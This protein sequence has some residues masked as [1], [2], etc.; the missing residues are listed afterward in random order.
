MRATIAIAAVVVLSCGSAGPAKITVRRPV[1][2]SKCPDSGPP[3][4]AKPELAETAG[5]AV[6]LQLCAFGD[7]FGLCNPSGEPTGMTGFWQ[8]S[9]AEVASIDSA[10][11]TFLGHQGMS[12]ET[13]RHLEQYGRQYLGFFRGARRYVFIN[14]F[15]RAFGI[16][17]HNAEREVIAVCDNS[18]NVEYDIGAHQFA[19]LA[20]NQG[21]RGR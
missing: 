9:P 11:S 6:A 12:G 15:P 13:V 8:L 1:H 16:T 5:W 10:L 20:I 4:A 14:A 7:G 17:R 19:N 18:W 2:N 3:V 21:P